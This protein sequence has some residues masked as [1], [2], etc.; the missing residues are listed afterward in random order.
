M[1]I[2]TLNAKE[3][4]YSHCL[5]ENYII[6]FPENISDLNEIHEDAFILGRGTN[7]LFKN[8]QKG[9]I[10]SLSKLTNYEVK[11]NIV[12][13]DAGITLPTLINKL[14]TYNLGGLEFTYP[15]LT[16]LGGAVYQNFGAYE[17]T[18]SELIIEVNCFNKKN[19]TQKT[20]TKQECLFNYRSSVFKAND[21]IITSVTL[22]LEK[23]DKTLIEKNCEHFKIKRETAYPLSYNLGSIFKNPTGLSAGKLIDECGLKGYEYKTV[24]VCNTHANI[25]LCN[26]N[27]TSEDF[28]KLIEIIKLK[29]KSKT[30]INLELE[31]VIY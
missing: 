30:D 29:V 21:Y 10:V 9:Q 8:K 11:G 31:I 6:H 16:S 24:K 27:S 4:S 3:L 7:T 5:G 28:L 20:L 19:K 22:L 13:A 15:I 12:Y 1:L 2:S 14:M 17:R 23:I 26:K 18:I 25:I